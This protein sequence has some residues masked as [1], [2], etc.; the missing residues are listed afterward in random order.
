MATV[1]GGLQLPSKETSED[2]DIV[3]SMCV[4]EKQTVQYSQSVEFQEW[5]VVRVKVIKVSWAKLC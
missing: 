3:A 2:K 5:S 1:K 4:S